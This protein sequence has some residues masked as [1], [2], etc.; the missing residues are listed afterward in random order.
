M[1]EKLEVK[2]ITPEGRKY[3][4]E[5]GE[6]LAPG[7][8]G[9]FGILPEHTEF[10]TRNVPG[11]VSIY[12]GH[13]TFH[14]SVGRGMIEVSNN[15]VLILVDTAEKA[16]EIDTKRAEKKFADVSE[17][18]EAGTFALNDPEYLDLLWAQKRAE[19]RLET[20]KR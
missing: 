1:S 5:A 8:K 14:F 17:K 10:L 19:A 20:S 7:N 9:Q 6:I 18:L 3:E 4:G 16:S 11:L 2:I 13:E 15:K 12:N